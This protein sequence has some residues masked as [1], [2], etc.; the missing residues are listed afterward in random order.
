[1][2]AISAA[3]NLPG[4]TLIYIPAGTYTINQTINLSNVKTSGIIFQG[5]GSANTEIVFDGLSSGA[6]CF[7]IFGTEG[8]IEMDVTENI[9]KGNSIIYGNFTNLNAGDWILLCETDF[10]DKY[11]QNGYVGQVS[12]LLSGGSSSI[13]MKDQASKSYLESNNLWVQE[14]SPIKNIGFENFKISR[15]NTTKGYGVNFHFNKAINCWVKGIESYICTGYHF[16]VH[17][18]SHIKIH[19]CYIHH[20]TNCDD[21]P[22]GTGYGISVAES[23]T[24]CLIEN[25]IF[26]KLRHAMIIGAGA[27]CNVF[28]YNYSR[29]QTW[30][31]SYTGSDICLHG[32]YPYAN[33]FEENLVD[34][35]MADPTHGLNGPYNTFLR[36]KTNDVRIICVFNASTTN[37]V[38]NSNTIK[39][40][41]EPSWV[42]GQIYELFTGFDIY[43]SENVMD[44]YFHGY[45]GFPNPYWQNVYYN[46]THGDWYYWKDDA[47]WLITWYSRSFLNDISYFYANR[48]DFLDLNYSWPSIGPRTNLDFDGF[49]ED[50]NEGI[51]AKDRYNDNIK[52]INVYPTGLSFYIYVPLDYPTVSSALVNS[53]YG[54]T[55]VVIGLNTISS[56]LSVPLGIE[57]KIQS[58]ATANLNSF[59]I[60]TTNGTITV[61]SGATINSSN[62]HTRLITGSG[63]KGI[64]STIASAMSAATSGQSIEVYGSHTLPRIS[65]F[66]RG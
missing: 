41:G 28:A 49:I 9:N 17:Q 47:Q 43:P 53:I 7:Q 6:D 30:N 33:L 21:D 56:N 31:H 36:N 39:V 14:I 46:F 18:C 52:T 48:P 23:T 20:A 32:R 37:V 11:P 12:Q 38:G 35:I 16:A 63:I 4:A 40:L 10:D 61:E 66:P 60:T 62:S 22:K 27:N 25:N 1:M 8:S 13:V 51:P 54:Q 19:G 65:P 15:T 42:I 44:L 24:N 55:I 26:R 64:Y 2:S 3:N 59:A 29:E 5:E 58:D 45:P 57:L 50:I 34:F